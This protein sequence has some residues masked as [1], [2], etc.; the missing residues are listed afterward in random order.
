MPQNI[1]TAFLHQ[2]FGR[3][4]SPANTNCM[5]IFKPLK[6]NFFRAFYLMTIRVYTFTFG[7]KHLSVA[8]FLTAY[9]KNNVV[10][11]RKISNI[12]HAISHLP[13]DGIK[14]FER[15]F[16]R[17]VLL[18]IINDTMKFVKTFRCLRIK[19]DVF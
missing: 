5:S 4:C 11:G 2:P 1:I 15:S 12:G 19:I 16:G 8:A 9:E 14:T 3:T 18:N 17:D 10:A 6:L 13:A 7:K